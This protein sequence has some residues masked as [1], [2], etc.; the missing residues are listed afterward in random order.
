MDRQ[1]I[2]IIIFVI[3]I[4]IIAGVYFI[5]GSNEQIPSQNVV[6]DMQEIDNIDHTNMV[7][8]I[9][10]P[11]LTTVYVAAGGGKEGFLADQDIHKI[12]I[13]KY[14]LNVVYDNW[15]N[16]K[17]VL[18]PVVREKIDRGNKSLRNSD[19]LTIRTEG[20][21]PYDAIFP[22]D[23]RYYDY[24]Q[25]PADKSKNEA[26][27]SRVQGGS[28]TLNTPIVI[29]SWDD[30]T[31]ALIKENIVTLRDGTYYITDMP[32]LMQYMLDKKKWKDIGLDKYYGS[33]EIKSVDPVVS[34]PGATY[35]GLL[36][37]IFCEGV[38]T[39][40][41][42]IQKFPELKDFYS[43]A[44]SLMHSPAD[45]FDAYKFQRTPLVVDYEKS[46]I[47]LAHDEPEYFA[48]IKDSI[49]VLYPEPTMW[50]SHCYEYFTDEGKQLFEAFKDPEIQKIAWERYG[51]R[52]GV[53]GGSY[54]TKQFG[55]GIPQNITQL[56]SGL[57]MN[58]YD[59]LT[60]Y[61][62]EKDEEK[63]YNILHD[64]TE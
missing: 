17:L 29:Y 21:T 59:K 1:L 22:S 46:I 6:V 24:F 7:D 53:A 35:Y 16:G 23:Q 62:G 27:R 4:V 25:L 33:V 15:S 31:E 2:G 61:L 19:N 10:I 56:V 26:D 47:N 42:A 12:L 40:E 38:V 32:K 8:N 55:I 44:G 54:D 57:K 13:E 30:V 28:L 20:A 58:I 43:K 9:D 36:L 48:Q 41:S 5:G 34:S 60:A 63:A 64:I 51:F 52:T 3:L 11:G 39:D 14:K 18:W 45:L 49:R 50:N 37:S